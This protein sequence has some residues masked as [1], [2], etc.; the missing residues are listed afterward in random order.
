MYGKKSFSY[1]ARLLGES[2]GKAH[3]STGKFT[4]LAHM[5][6]ICCVHNASL[7]VIRH[8]ANFERIRT[9]CKVTIITDSIRPSFL[10][11]LKNLT[12]N[13]CRSSASRSG[14]QKSSTISIEIGSSG[15]GR[16]GDGIGVP[17]RNSNEVSRTSGSSQTFD[18]GRV[19][20]AQ[21]KGSHRGGRVP[22]GPTYVTRAFFATHANV[23]ILVLQMST[24]GSLDGGVSIRGGIPKGLD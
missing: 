19:G 1:S 15:C 5:C 16:L 10:K 7:I 9:T 2:K 4:S 3:D 22:F 23:V 8:N 17:L 6:H 12:A 14:I 20:K 11:S 13:S 24:G 18:S 21:T